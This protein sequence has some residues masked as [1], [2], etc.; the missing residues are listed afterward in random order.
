MR[1]RQRV[2]CGMLLVGVGIGC[3]IYAYGIYAG[4]PR[5]NWVMF[6]GK[7]GYLSDQEYVDHLRRLERSIP[8]VAEYR[9][10]AQREAAKRHTARNVKVVAAAAACLACLIPGIIVI[11]TGDLAGK[12][13]GAA[14]H[15]T[16]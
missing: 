6:K 7:G 4:A 9:K 8:D 1:Y 3:A 12:P 2:S 14:P 15:K 11:V 10:Q 5:G 13:G 16:L